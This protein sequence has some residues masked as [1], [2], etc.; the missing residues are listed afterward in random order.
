MRLAN[1]FQYQASN[2]PPLSELV[3]SVFWKISAHLAMHG[4]AK[5]KLVCSFDG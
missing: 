2:V 3:A 4:M 1:I 5:A